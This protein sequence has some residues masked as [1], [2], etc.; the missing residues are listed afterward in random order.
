MHTTSPSLLEQLRQ[1]DQPA[2]W[3]RFAELYTPLLYYWCRRLGLDGEEARD[4]VQDV[5]VVLVDQLPKFAYDPGKRF[6][7]WL[8]TVAHNKWRERHRRAGRLPITHGADL[9]EIADGRD[10]DVL[11]E[12]EHV[13]FLTA[14]AL[15]LI[16]PQFEPQTWE[17]FWEYAIQGRPAAEVAR[18]L[19][20]SPNAVYIAKSRVQT[21]LREEFKEFLD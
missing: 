14:R 19:G 15:E 16:K 12:A 8:R 2:A 17:A 1:P 13:R 9:D 18:A 21:R 10:A 7:S 6:R 11:E 3:D 5:F 4:L 20:L